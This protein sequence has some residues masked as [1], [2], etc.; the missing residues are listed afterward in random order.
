MGLAFIPIYIEYLGIEAYGLIGLFA[1]LQTWLVLLD[2]GMS[3]ALGREMARLKGGY[4]SAEYIRDLLRSVE[5]VAASMAFLICAGSWAVSSWLASNWLN[6]ENLSTQSVAHAFAMIGVVIAV[7]SVEGIYRSSIIGLQRQ[8]LLNAIIS[9]MATMRG[10]GAVGVLIYISPTIEGFFLWQG[11]VSLATLFILASVTYH[12]LPRSERFG[13]FSVDALCEIWRFAA[14]ML[15]ITFLSLMLMQVDKIVLSRLVTLSEF[16]YYMLASAIAGLLAMVSHPII[17]AYFPR[18]VELHASGEERHFVVTYHQ[19]AQ[20]ITATTGS[21][22][23]VL[24]LFSEQI[25]MLWTSDAELAS[26]TAMLL[27]LLALGNFL[28][29]LV[30]MPY[31]AQLVYGWTS[32]ALKINA[33]AVILV[34]PLILLVAPQYGAEGAALVWVCLNIVYLVI[35]VH[36]M[37][38]KILK[39]EQW[40]WWGIDVFVPLGAA[41]ISAFL[42]ERFFFVGLV[43]PFC[44]FLEILAIS[45]GSLFFA[46]LAAPM[47]R[48][49]VIQVIKK[50]VI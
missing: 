3:P 4:V 41:S 2:M 6:A 44:Q 16:G 11:V 19:G 5:F 49:R 36:L 28:N 18:L 12:S 14:G 43:S 24:I 32:L 23:I 40:Y 47:I 48:M 17:Q 37:Y 33:S 21:A 30:L 13:R 1:V 38:R 9:A 39:S 29:A 31:Q 7:R 45:S 20:L 8:V 35:G 42:M 22:A 27:R 26:R 34:V 50:L 46:G 25:L 15:G 10:F